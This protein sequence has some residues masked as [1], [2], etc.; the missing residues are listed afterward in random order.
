MNCTF[1]V[2]EIE[3]K[4]QNAKCWAWSCANVCNYCTSQKINAETGLLS[5]KIGFDTAENRPSKV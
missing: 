1:L 4:G 3:L 5:A 2:D